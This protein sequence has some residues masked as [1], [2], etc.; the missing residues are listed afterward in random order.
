MNA[1]PNITVIASLIADPSRAVFLEALLDG[2]ALPAGELAYMAGV[3][4]QTASNHL[5]KLVEGGLLVVERQGRHR[6]YR[7]AGKEI[8]FLIETMG[9]IAPPVQVRSLKQS[10]QLQ[11]L[12]FARTCYGHL[13]GKLGIALCEALLREGYLEE[14]EDEQSKDYQITAKGVQWFNSFGITLEGKTGSRRTLA[15]KCLDWSERRHHISGLLGDE[16]G[17]RLS[18]LDWTH[19]KP[20]S[21]AVEVTEA[22][23]KGLYE[24][25]GISL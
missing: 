7:L 19:Q 23:K 10:N 17:R 18:E 14:S 21:R 24:V 22:G 15:R 13:A 9:S 16:L 2:R 1:Y 20:G 12:S 5:A 4:P 11:H 3:T 25:L 6:Y 8:A